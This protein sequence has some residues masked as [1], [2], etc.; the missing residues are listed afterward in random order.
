MTT[1]L[2]S[3]PNKDDTQ[4]VWLLSKTNPLN[5]LKWTTR[6]YI[7]LNCDDA[8]R[9]KTAVRVGVCW[10]VPHKLF[11][12]FRFIRKVVIQVET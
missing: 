4:T 7:D 3:R 9:R 8:P 5:R 10:W 12:Y 11:I 6:T 1:F 2:D